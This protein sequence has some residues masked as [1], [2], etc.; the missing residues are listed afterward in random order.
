M[1]LLKRLVTLVWTGAL[2][3][4][5]CVL[6]LVNPDTVTVD[7]V[8]LEIPETSLS[9]ILFV[10]FFIGVITGNTI[11]FIASLFRTTKPRPLND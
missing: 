5:G 11:F 4:I 2:L 8:W 6:Y 10:T 7:L 9:V 1:R 3:V